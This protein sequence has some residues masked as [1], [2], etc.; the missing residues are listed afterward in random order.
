MSARIIKCYT[1]ILNLFIFLALVIIRVIRN[2]IIKYFFQIQILSVLTIYLKIKKK[3]QIL[4]AL[5][6][7][8]S[9]PVKKIC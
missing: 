8:A 4:K 9:C 6:A 3:K 5:V 1:L 7:D 2:S